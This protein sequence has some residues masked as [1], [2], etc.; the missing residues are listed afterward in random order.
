[1]VKA[2]MQQIF[3]IAI[4]YICSDFIHTSNALNLKIVSG[5]GDRTFP[6]LHDCRPT[7][8]WLIVTAY[9]GYTDGSFGNFLQSY[10]SYAMG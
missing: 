9:S 10:E 3:Y 6:A 8:T 4:V 2:L 5:K 1:M 7:C